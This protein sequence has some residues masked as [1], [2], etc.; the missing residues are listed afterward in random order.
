[1]KIKKRVNSLLIFLLFCFAG[2]GFAQKYPIKSV[3]LVVPFP[4]GASND[5]IARLVGQGLAAGFGQTFVIDNRGGAGGAIGAEIVAKS[6]SD[7]YT[8]MLT[9]TSYVTNAA[10]QDK[11]NFNPM[12]DITGVAMIGIAPMLIVI[13]PSISVFSMQD[14]IVIAKSQP[15]KINYASSGTGSAVHL[16]TEAFMNAANIKM[17]HV[18]YKGLGPALNDLVAGQV[19]LLIA[20]PPSVFPQVKNNRLRAIAVTSPIRSSFFPD[21]PTLIESGLVKFYTEQWWGLFAPGRLS[22]DIQ[23]ILNKEITRFL[24]SEKMKQQLSTEGAEPA[25]MSMH[26][27]KKFIIND[28][29]KWKKVVLISGIKIE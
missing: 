7:G 12:I 27:F 17:T 13:H 15:G 11:P 20:S 4:P 29:E 24:Q 6:A 1:M 18:P 19:Q 5:V 16:V 28:I 14:L 25:T 22:I 8:L 9:S 2:L 10:L 26:E 21:L 3:R 23:M